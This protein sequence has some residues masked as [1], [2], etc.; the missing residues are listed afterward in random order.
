MRRTLNRLTALQVSRLR[1]PGSYADGGGLYLHVRKAGTRAWVFRY[2]LNSRAREKGLGPVS[3][4]SL[5]EARAKAQ[6]CRRLKA[7][8]IDPIDAGRKQHQQAQIEAA[9]RI[10]FK[11]CAEAYIASHAVSWRNEKHVVQ[12][13]RTLET[14][15]YRVIG[16]LPTQAIDTGLVLRILEPIWKSKTETASRLRGRIE[17]VLDWASSRGYRSGDNPARWR[18]HLEN[19]LPQRSKVRR[20]THHAALHYTNIGA[21]MAAL[22]TQ[23]AIAPRA[24]EFLILTAT[25]TS[26]TIGAAWREIDFQARIWTIPAERIKA[27]KE[28]RVPLTKQAVAILVEMKAEQSAAGLD[29]FPYVFRGIRK[30]EP[31]SNMS[32]LKL[33]ERMGRSDITVHGFRSTFRDWAAECTTYPREVAEMALAHAIG[34][35]VE[36]AYR[37]GDLFEKRKAMMADWAQY[38]ETLHHSVE[39]GQDVRNV[40]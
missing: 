7:S 38:C 35:K 17:T 18:G 33:L 28:H 27:G 15:A 24:L 16:N 29:A 21:F 30:A 4:V 37:R 3:D 1:T 5:A 40:A 25:R 26:E 12:W 8:G 10:S 2:M 31:L 23:T 19:L 20:V 39:L 34:D 32:M 11:Q 14:Y 36:A 9:S 6:E 13:R 22:R